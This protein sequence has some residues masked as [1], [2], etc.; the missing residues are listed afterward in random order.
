L[1]RFFDKPSLQDKLRITIGTAR[2]NDQLL[3]ALAAL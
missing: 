1:V 3:A 2:E